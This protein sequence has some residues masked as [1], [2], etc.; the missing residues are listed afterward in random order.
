[1]TAPSPMAV[2]AQPVPATPA[3]A[4]ARP[5]FLVIGL[6]FVFGCRLL[7][8]AWMPER[9]SDFDLLYNAAARL[10]GGDNPYAPAAQGLPYPLSAVLLAVPFTTIPLML[11]RPIFDVL[12]GW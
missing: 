11:A 2:T 3:A 9:N 5:F 8:Y 6:A 12:V 4:P 10:I 1:M 7:L